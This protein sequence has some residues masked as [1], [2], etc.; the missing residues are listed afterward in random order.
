[1]ETNWIILFVAIVGVLAIIGFLLKSFIKVILVLG[2]IYLLFHLGFIWGV[3]DLNE[4]LHLDK[5]LKPEVSQQIQEKYD[6]F[7]NRREENGVVETQLIEK[8]I[9]DSLQVA[10][11]KASD[12][13]RNIDKEALIQDLSDKLRN[14]DTEEV[15]QALDNL[16][17]ELAKYNV[18]PEEVQVE[19]QSAQ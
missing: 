9:N 11:T 17:A 7:S 2:V 3:G 12:E 4:K 15:A 5:F 19:T 18:T 6:D 1:M 8:T 13:I 16:K 10:L 14:F